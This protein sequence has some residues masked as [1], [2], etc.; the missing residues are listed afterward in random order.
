[1]KLKWRMKLKMTP[2]KIILINLLNLGLTTTDFK[3]STGCQPT[4]KF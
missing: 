2:S 4:E 1:M 3:T